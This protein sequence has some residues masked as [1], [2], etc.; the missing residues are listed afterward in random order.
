MLVPICLNVLLHLPL[1]CLR[2]HV[3]TLCLLVLR[4]PPLECLWISLGMGYALVVWL[5]W[6]ADMHG[7]WM[8]A[9]GAPITSIA[10]GCWWTL[11]RLRATRRQACEREGP[12][13]DDA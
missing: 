6:G 12:I 2:S 13:A 4:R 9:F 8:V 3:I 11:W 1:R 7:K 5:F 10:A